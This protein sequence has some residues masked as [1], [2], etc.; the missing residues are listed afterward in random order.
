MRT[1]Y[2]QE[3]SASKNGVPG[4]CRP[5]L[6]FFFP[7]RFMYN[8]SRAGGQA[9]TSRQNRGATTHEG[10]ALGAVHLL[11]LS[12][13]SG[14][15]ALARDE[16]KRVDGVDDQCLLA[17][18]GGRELVASGPHHGPL[19]DHL[20]RGQALLARSPYH[21]AVGGHQGGRAADRH[22]LNVRTENSTEKFQLNSHW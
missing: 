13:R 15:D 14:Q 8:T 22:P 9:A 18:A 3:I 7:A 5:L 19:G 6:S 12:G 20:A 21:L 11:A 2:K 16:P 4:F 17:G 10:L 1:K